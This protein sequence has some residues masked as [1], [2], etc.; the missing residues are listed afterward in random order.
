MATLPG[1][2]LFHE[3]Q[4]EGRKIKPPIF[5]GR[6]PQETADEELQ[7]F[8]AALL[9]TIRS[10]VFRDGEW[11]LCERTGWPDNQSF[12]NLVAWSW[13]K[14]EDRFLI[15]VNFS[16]SAVQ[17]RVKVPWEDLRGITWRLTDVFSGATYDREGDE[18][19]DPGL[20]VEM[21]SWNWNFFRCGRAATSS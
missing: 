4:F 9:K 12:Q 5:L 16:D 15:V 19:S 1:A 18:M 6:R 8:Y 2:R 21:D 11:M 10:P 17:A 3:G 20:Y 13:R 14:G 7:S